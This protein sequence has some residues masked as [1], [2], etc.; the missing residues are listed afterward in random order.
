MSDQES[1]IRV[2]ELVSQVK[3][4][5]P[6]ASFPVPQSAKPEKATP[7]QLSMP[8]E[9]QCF[10]SLSAYQLTH[11]SKVALVSFYRHHVEGLSRAYQEKHA[12]VVEGLTNIGQSDKS[13]LDAFRV[14]LERRF[15]LH[16]EQMWEIGLRE[17]RL[18]CWDSTHDRQ[19]SKDDVRSLEAVDKDCKANRGHDSDAVRILEQAFQQTQNI[20]QAEKYRLAEVTGLQPKQVTIWVSFFYSIDASRY[21]ASSQHKRNRP[22]GEEGQLYL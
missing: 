21:S 4:S 9:H 5:L 18:Y 6:K 3:E 11:N 10:A 8:R 13:F 12:E 15:L 17:V 19:A 7:L 16:C 2:L 20:T 1:L 22:N 14:S